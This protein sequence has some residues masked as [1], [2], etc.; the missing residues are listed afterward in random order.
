MHVDDSSQTHKLSGIHSVD[1]C[2]REAQQDSIPSNLRSIGRMQ[3][4]EQSQGAGTGSPEGHKYSSASRLQSLQMQLR[5]LSV[6]GST[7]LLAVACSP[8]AFRQNA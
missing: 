2:K 1:D 7:A 3:R 4:S 5:L 8:H 6:S